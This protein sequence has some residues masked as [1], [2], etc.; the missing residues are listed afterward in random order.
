MTTM[1]SMEAF[2][3]AVVITEELVGSIGDEQFALPTPC[4]EWTVRGVL[5]HVLL[6]DLLCHAW[7]NGA[8]PPDREMDHLG[9]DPRSAVRQGLAETRRLVSE[10]GTLIR[11]IGTRMG[12]M[13]VA[14]L[15]DRRVADLTAH[16]WDL[17]VA[18]GKSTAYD[19]DLVAY[20]EAHYRGRL[21]GK[22]RTGP[23]L[24]EIQPVPP[25]ATAADRLAGYLGRARELDA[26]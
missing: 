22:P 18:L 1:D 6:G 17:A 20:A 2:E 15:I 25:G 11:V 10:P 13:P 26:H 5:N 14:A 4:S 12:E 23:Q 21:D 16:L 8:T 3:R 19:P 24:A 9:A 7:I